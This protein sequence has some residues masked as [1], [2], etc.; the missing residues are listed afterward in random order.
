MTEDELLIKAPPA[1]ATPP[2]LFHIIVEISPDGRDTYVLTPMTDRALSLDQIPDDR[3]YN[4]LGDVAEAVRR[5][6]TNTMTSA[7]LKDMFREG[8]NSF[9]ALTPNEITELRRLA[10]Q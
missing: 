7:A 4:S 9:R 6:P 10:A 3:R 1:G 8:K 2:G 5:L